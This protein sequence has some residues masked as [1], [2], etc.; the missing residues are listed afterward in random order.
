MRM[1]LSVKCDE[2][3]SLSDDLGLA[4]IEISSLK[5][6]L[7]VAEMKTKETVDLLKMKDKELE[8]LKKLVVLLALIS[9]IFTYIFLIFHVRV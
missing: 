2:I 7:S 8:K 9:C 4:K 5:Q 6:K 3:L 1:K